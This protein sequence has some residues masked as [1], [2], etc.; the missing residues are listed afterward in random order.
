MQERD[1]MVNVKLLSH[2]HCTVTLYNKWKKYNTLEYEYWLYYW[3]RI[4]WLQIQTMDIYTVIHSMT[5]LWFEDCV[6]RKLPLWFKAGHYTKHQDRDLGE[7]ESRSEAN[8]RRQGKA[9]C[10]TVTGEV[11]QQGVFL[12]IAI[13]IGLKKYYQS[14]STGKWLKAYL[15]AGGG[16]REE[17][18]FSK[19]VRVGGSNFDPTD[20]M[21]GGRQVRRAG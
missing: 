12:T 15:V 17:E 3:D 2:K 5:W 14:S 21:Q 4:Q 9:F 6:L 7:G 13:L 10:E 8:W 20:E 18:E 11:Y 16:L 19:E 1:L